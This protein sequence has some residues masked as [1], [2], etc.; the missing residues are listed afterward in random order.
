MRGTPHLPVLA[1]AENSTAHQCVKVL[2][3]HKS[4]DLDL[5]IEENKQ[6]YP[7]TGGMVEGVMMRL[8]TKTKGMTRCDCV[9]G[10]GSSLFDVV[11]VQNMCWGRR[12][13]RATHVALVE[14]CIGRTTAW[15]R[16]HGIRR[17]ASKNKRDIRR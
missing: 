7:A 3:N 10:G 17:R 4:G 9:C 8:C 11:A 14:A 16:P 15:G 5:I 12:H 1:R 13:A 2:R 6:S